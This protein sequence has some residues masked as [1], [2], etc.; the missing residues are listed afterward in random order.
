MRPIKIIA[1]SAVA[2][3][4]LLAF[5][6]PAWSE[7]TP[8]V[9]TTSADQTGVAITVYNDGTGLVKDTREIAM[10]EGQF[11]LRFMDVASSMD[12]TSVHFV[13]LTDP[14]AIGVLEQNYEYDLVSTQAL[15]EAYVDKPVMV[16]TADNQTLEGILLSASD[17]LIIRTG[18]GV[19]IITNPAEV[20]FGELPEGL[21]TRPTLRWSLTN[22]GPSPQQVEMSY[23]T[24]GLGW[25]ANYVAVVG[26]NDDKLDLSGWVTINNT[27]GADYYDAVLKLVAGQVN[28]VQPPMPP[29]MATNG[30]ALG[31]AAPVPQF[32]EESFFEYHL[33]TL[34]QPATV[35]NNQQKQLSLLERGGVR[36]TKVLV[37]NQGYGSFYEGSTAQGQIQVKL[38]F[39]NSEEN[40]LGIP[41]P[42]GTVRVYKQ[43]SSGSLQFIGEDSINHTP[44]DEE[45]EL[46]LGEAFDVVGERSVMDQRQISD[47]IWEY[48]MKV[49]IRNHKNEAI[50][51][52]YLDQFW[53]QW[54]IRNSS[55]GYNQKDAST[56]EWTIPVPSNGETELTYTVRMKS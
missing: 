3:A 29:P 50:D 27:S 16:R 19:V 21:I 33:Y 56:A 54:E 14:N 48:D 44:K 25:S 1:L 31:A 17:G 6:I 52:L 7:E 4:I 15:Y 2:I 41:L 40:G 18:S 24:S 49:T 38:K 11:N 35:L 32:V 26:A 20:S 5:H 46:Y 22:N 51:V 47:S 23:L 43:D 12:P 10:P 55:L 45:L 53:G 42:A 30:Y 8:V 39:M 36:A 9:D 13:S 28:K 37:F 34:D